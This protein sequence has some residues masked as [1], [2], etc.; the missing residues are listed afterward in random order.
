LAHELL[1]TNIKFKTGS[2]KDDIRAED[3]DL[4][5]SATIRV[6]TALD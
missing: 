6:V 1:A 3:C 2:V 5:R 4:E